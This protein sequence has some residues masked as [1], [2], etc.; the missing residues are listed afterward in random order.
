MHKKDLT[1]ILIISFIITTFGFLIDS[2]PMPANLWITV[3]EYFAMTTLIF[4]VITIFYGTS[5]FIF[6]N[7]KQKFHKE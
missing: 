7:I 2:D 6:K 5:K 1:S 3:F 4:I